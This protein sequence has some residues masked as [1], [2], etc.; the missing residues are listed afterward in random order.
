MNLVFL[1]K[2][3]ALECL[4]WVPF[5]FTLLAR[6]AIFNYN[7]ISIADYKPDISEDIADYKPDI[8]EDM[9][10]AFIIRGGKALEGTIEVRGAK[11]TVFPLLAATLLTKK[12]SSIGNLPLIEDV[13]RMIELLKSMGAEIS[14]LGKQKIKVQT[15]SVDPVKINDDLVTQLRG[16]VL[17]MGP[18]LA[19]FGRARMARPGGC[20]IGARP[21]DTHTDAFRQLG[22]EIEFDGDFYELK[23]TPKAEN[24]VVILNEFSVTGT[25]NAML[26]AANRPGKTIIKGADTDYQVQELA[27]FLRLMGAKIEILPQ[28]TI[29]IE[30]NNEL[31]GAEY[32]L[33]YDPIE[34]GT[35]IL[36]AAATR[37][38]V[39]VRNV[40]TG[41]LDLFFKR[42]S[43][44][45]LPCKI[46]EERPGFGTVK[47]SPWRELYI[48]RLQSLPYPGL[49]SDLLSAFGVLATQAKGVTLVHDPLYEGRLK[50][51]EELNRMGANIIFCDPHRAVINGPTPLRGR[52]LK[53]TDL[54]G[55]AALVIAG[56]VADGESKV[57]NVYQID[58]GY[59]KIEERLQKL[60]ADIKR[61]NTEA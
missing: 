29:L 3:H 17:F 37:G 20:L 32:D 14:W 5:L 31:F 60:G 50:Y 54:R 39:A 42:L 49:Q 16:S 35:F 43:S 19:R 24:A 47:V 30:G 56:L 22:A 10:E 53:T 9:R 41:F 34:A 52:V 18:L 25:E 40:E 59:E 23:L 61:I 51:L 7:T 28:H 1:R 58:R 57:E 27:R 21:I 11:N 2:L 12:P 36:T 15:A 4:R 26:F 8:S 38:N 45:G 33:M 55:G 46:E 48:D 13:F 44:F 6:V